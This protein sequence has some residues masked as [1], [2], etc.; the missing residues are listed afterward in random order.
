MIA[1]LVPWVDQHFRT[2]PNADGRAMAGLSMGG[3]QTLNTAL[4][5]L[6]TFH[7]VGVFGSGWFNQAD[8][9]WFYDNRQDVIAA[10]NKQLKVFDWGWGAVDFA[11]PGAIE[12]T[13][14]LKSR[15][16]KLTTTENQGGHDWRTWRDD[17]HRFAQ[18]IFR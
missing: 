9:Q 10:I 8:R 18:M 11:K 3:I 6:S 17:L 16:V 2:V 5:N 15:G 1:D 7:H 14:Y 13:D 4:N 12:I